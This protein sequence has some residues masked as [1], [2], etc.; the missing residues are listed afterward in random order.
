MF[1]QIPLPPPD[2]YV[3][4]HSTQHVCPPLATTRGL[5]HPVAKVQPGGATGVGHAVSSPLGEQ[6]R[7]TVHPE[8]KS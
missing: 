7:K 6:A 2:R 8:D 3:N 5:R 4:T 1:A